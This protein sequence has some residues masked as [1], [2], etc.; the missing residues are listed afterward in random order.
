MITDSQLNTLAIF[1]GTLMMGLIVLYHFL[2]IN[3]EDSKIKTKASE[4]I[5]KLKPAIVNAK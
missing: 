1:L 5:S 2:A 4:T 3:S